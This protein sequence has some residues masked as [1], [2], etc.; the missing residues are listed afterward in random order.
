MSAHLE[1]AHD[2][3]HHSL[4]LCSPLPAVVVRRY[5][6]VIQKGEQFLAVASQPLLQ[7]SG[8]LLLLFLVDKL[9]QT[10]SD[11]G[12]PSFIDFQHHSLSGFLQ[13]HAVP[14]QAA[15]PP[16][17]I[18]PFPAGIVVLPGSASLFGFWAWTSFP[19]KFFPGNWNISL[20]I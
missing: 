8:V 19:T 20:A 4:G 17:K 18:Q 16:V 12:L 14:D 6:V 10:L 7:S 15:Q 11:S 9:V 2:G 1:G 13:P 3:H 5:F